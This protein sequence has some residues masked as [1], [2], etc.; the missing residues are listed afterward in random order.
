MNGQ[1]S[2]GMN[3]KSGRAF[4]KL[5]HFAKT[6][7]RYWQDR[8]ANAWTLLQIRHP[9][10]AARSFPSDFAFARVGPK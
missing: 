8:K 7:V 6:D 5:G 2:A 1:T 4:G 3:Q 9:L 10:L